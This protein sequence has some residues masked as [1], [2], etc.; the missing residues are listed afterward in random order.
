MSAFLYARAG[1]T[2]RALIYLWIAGVPFLI[3]ASWANA[4]QAARRLEVN[5]QRE[6]A[7]RQ[8]FAPPS[9]R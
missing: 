5:K 8:K 4:D 3:A 6:L 7:E 1:R 2:Y 9:D